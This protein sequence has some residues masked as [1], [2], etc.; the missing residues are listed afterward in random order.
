MKKILFVSNFYYACKQIGDYHLEDIFLTSQ[1]RTSFALSICHPADTEPYEDD[2]DLILFRNGGVVMHYQSAYDAWL[3]RV[4]AKHL[5]TYNSPDGK[6]DMRGKDYLLELTKLNFPVIPTTDRLDA[7][8]QL[9]AVNQFVLKPK[10]GA[11]SIGFRVLPKAQLLGAPLPANTLI[12]PYIDFQY[13]VSFYFIDSEFQYALYAPD[14]QRRWNLV[15]YQPSEA[16][17]AFA[18]RF[19]AWNNLTWG[20][21]RIDACRTPAGDLLLLEVEDLSPYLSLLQLPHG[22]R[23]RF[24]KSLI[25]SLQTVLDESTEPESVGQPSDHLIEQMAK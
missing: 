16:D 7:L 9:P 2:C 23:D 3:E 12:Q 10:N 13:E 5:K 14:K 19:I 11:D 8:D 22:I 18:Y 15:T 24:V 1:L 17:L 20:I 25:Q 6:G 4:S 21:Q